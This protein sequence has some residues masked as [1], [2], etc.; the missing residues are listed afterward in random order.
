[1]GFDSRFG[2]FRR[3]QQCL[4]WVIPLLNY[5]SHLPMP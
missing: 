3:L 1:M 4:M 2:N 5:P